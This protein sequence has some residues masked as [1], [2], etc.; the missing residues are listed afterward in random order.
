VRRAH[1]TNRT[2][3]ALLALLLAGAGWIAGADR[4]ADAGDPAA[5][6]EAAEDTSRPAEERAELARAARRLAGSSGDPSLRAAALLAL[7]RAEL[8]LGR[9]R[10]ALD[11]LHRAER[12]LRAAGDRWN[13][14]RCLRRIGDV[15]FRLGSHQLALRTYL[16]AM[17]LLEPLAGP[18]APRKRR[19]ALGHLAVMLGNVL[20]AVGDREQA[21]RDY[22][23]GAEIYAREGYD[24]GLAGVLLNLG[25]LDEERG[26]RERALRRYARALQIARR[27]GDRG[28]ERMALTNHAATLVTLGRLDGAGD[29][30]AAAVALAKELG[31]RRGLMHARRTVGDLRRA[32]GRVG[33]AVAA[34]REALSLAGRLH[35]VQLEMELHGT[36]ADL[37]LDLGRRREAVRH[38][39]AERRLRRE[40]AASETAAAVA[41]LRLAYEAERRE[42]ELALAELEA[43]QQRT[44]TRLLALALALAVGLL[45][46]TGWGL[47]TRSRLAEE[48]AARHRALAEAYRRLEE[49]SRTDDLTGLPNRRAGLE[50]LREELA[51]AAR[52]GTPCAVA[53]LDLDGFK[54]VNDTLGHAA[55]DAVLAETAR[56]GAASLRAGDL[57]ARWGGD[58]LMAILPG[59][60]PREA[61][62]ALE[63]LLD[64]VAGRPV[65][66]EDHELAVSLSAGMV[67]FQGNGPDLE[68]LLAEAD[69]A[70]YRAKRA[71]GGRIEIA[72]GESPDRTAPPRGGGG[73]AAGTGTMEP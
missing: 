12:L 64:A 72:G 43:R 36:L 34:Y 30:L 16:E 33:E 44:R 61:R 38:L 29:E 31:D 41:R 28:L 66:W 1:P 35:D 11:A 4:P 68:R 26:D 71:G 40:R 27:I 49:V 55:G 23:R 59:A 22:R 65:R 69:R 67:T 5:L 50:R 2:A 24:L 3:A 8:D 53:L 20:R 47:W 42:E 70:L 56:R 62:E 52:A 18:D 6:V 32:Q 25:N 14:V 54:A 21:A 17:R 57:L 73:H 60:G 45:G 63:R 7:G 39:L 19:L 58:E 37:L 48:V 46:V 15:Q 13:H 10:E 51:R 9:Y